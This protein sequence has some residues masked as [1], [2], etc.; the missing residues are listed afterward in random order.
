MAYSPN[1]KKEI[2]ALGEYDIYHAQGIWQYPTYAIVDV[3]KKK[4]NLI[5]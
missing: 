1:L 5:L 4:E 3:A 2:S